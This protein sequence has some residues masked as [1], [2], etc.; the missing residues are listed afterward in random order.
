MDKIT[1]ALESS[2]SS[3][4]SPSISNRSAHG[5]FLLS[6]CIHVVFLV[7][8]F[9]RHAFH[10]TG[11]NCPTNASKVI[12]F[13]TGGALLV[14]SRPGSLTGVGATATSAFWWLI[15]LAWLLVWHVAWFAVLVSSATLGQPFFERVLFFSGVLLSSR[16]LSAFK[17]AVKSRYSRSAFRLSAFDLQLRI[18]CSLISYRCL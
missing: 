9:V 6:Y 17:R 18:V 15:G 4:G 8:V 12:E 2:I 5:L 14:S 3:T 7:C 13:A 11:W 1:K 10:W 16:A